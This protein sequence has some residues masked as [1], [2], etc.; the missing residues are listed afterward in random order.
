MKEIKIP[1]SLDSYKEGGYEVMTNGDEKNQ[2]IKV[3]FQFNLFFTQIALKRL[4]AHH[5][6]VA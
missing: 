4:S 2:P 1:F 5:E 3:S 6:W